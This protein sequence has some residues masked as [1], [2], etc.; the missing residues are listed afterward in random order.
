VFDIFSVKRMYNIAVNTGKN[1]LI[2]TKNGDA[3]DDDDDDD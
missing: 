3:D 2:F 1:N